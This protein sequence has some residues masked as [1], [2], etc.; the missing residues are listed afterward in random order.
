MRPL[1]SVVAFAES[2]APA[3]DVLLFQILLKPVA[4][5]GSCSIEPVRFH[6]AYFAFPLFHDGSSIAF[7]LRGGKMACPFHVIFI[8]A[9]T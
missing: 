5:G 4:Q 7:A 1:G 9:C 2:E 8:Y 3:I 6:D